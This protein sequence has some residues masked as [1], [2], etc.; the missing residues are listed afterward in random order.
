LGGD[1]DGYCCIR[2]R[3]AVDP[4]NSARVYLGI[5]GFASPGMGTDHVF[6][7]SDGGASWIDSG[8]VASDSGQWFGG[9]AISSQGPSMV[10]VGTGQGVFAFSN[11]VTMGVH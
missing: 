9:L 8:L 7:S 5:A 1:V 2:K 3:L 11:A 6:Q 4:Q 10:Y